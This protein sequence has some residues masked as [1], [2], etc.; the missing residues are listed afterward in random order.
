MFVYVFVHLFVYVVFGNQTLPFCSFIL[1]KKALFLFA[2]VALVVK[3]F[4][5]YLSMTCHK[6]SLD[7]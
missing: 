1:V 7:I 3:G 6:L 2:Y 4:F 5:K